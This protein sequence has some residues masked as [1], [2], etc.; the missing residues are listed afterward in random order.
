MNLPPEAV[1]AAIAAIFG[2]L[3]WSMKADRADA[4]KDRDL[5]REMAT[6]SLDK[7]ATGMESMAGA[8]HE[9]IVVQKELTGQVREARDDIA[10]LTPPPVDTRD[11]VTQPLGKVI[12]GGREAGRY[13]QTRKPSRGG[14]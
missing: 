10:E 13:S 14:G 9:M 8:I 4:A 11:D 3:I 12:P 5:L 1:I 6:K 7:V 2:A